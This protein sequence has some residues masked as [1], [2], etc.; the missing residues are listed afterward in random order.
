MSNNNATAGAGGAGN[1][2]NSMLGEKAVN[3]ARKDG[4]AQLKR[5]LLEFMQKTNVNAKQIEGLTA[6]TIYDALK[7]AAKSPEAFV[8][9]IGSDEAGKKY[10]MAYFKKIKENGT[11]AKLLETNAKRKASIAT[12]RGR[13]VSSTGIRS[14]SAST[15]RKVS[16]GA[17]KYVADLKAVFKEKLR[18]NKGKPAKIGIQAIA[19][20]KKHLRSKYPDPWT[21]SEDKLDDL[22][23][24]NRNAKAKSLATRRSTSMATKLGVNKAELSDLET[25]RKSLE[26]RT[27]KISNE[28]LKKLR[29][30]IGTKPV[31]G[32]ISRI[33]GNATTKEE[34][35]KKLKEFLR[36]GASPT[37]RKRKYDEC[38]AKCTEKYPVI[39]G[40]GV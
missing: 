17:T 32:A 9:M 16:P 35:G 8:K 6:S 30:A 4:I 29:N 33:I 19:Y 10:R 12:R 5:D 3:T 36:K 27:L 7:K 21:M 28:G 26:K 38:V 39:A 13:S 11:L 14:A 22:R 20:A 31:E 25:I 40:A 15:T 34:I 18:D 24:V 37:T 1:N 23:H 2:L